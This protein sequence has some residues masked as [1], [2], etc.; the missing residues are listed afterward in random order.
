MRDRLP[1]YSI[2]VA[3][4]TSKFDVGRAT[5][6]P[7]RVSRGGMPS[8]VWKLTTDRGVFSVKRVRRD[9]PQWWLDT[10]GA[11]MD[12]E[13]R[14]LASGVT[15]PE[16]IPPISDGLGFMA[17]IGGVPFRV[18]RWIDARP[19]TA[20]ED[21]A[22][23][24]GRTLAILHSLM[25]TDAPD[26]QEYGLHPGSEWDEWISQARRQRRPWS[27]AA[28]AT[29]SSLMDATEFVE[30]ALAIGDACCYAHRDFNPWNFFI[31]DDG[32]AVIDFDYAGPDVAWLEL[33][34][35][36][37]ELAFVGRA[38]PDVAVVRT[39]VDAY[40]CAGGRCG[41][42]SGPLALGRWVGSKLMWTAWNMWRSLGHRPTTTPLEMAEAD[43]IVTQELET[44]P[45]FLSEIDRWSQLVPEFG[46]GE[47]AARV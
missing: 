45:R 28:V 4:I 42:A 10:V 14:A 7:L 11:S 17:L 30:A 34:S 25:P 20:L 13:R 2:D 40:V 27:D 44:W 8:T 21:I 12:F 18:H 46:D 15:V 47:G 38:E 19:V 1:S 43:R 35:S 37:V 29:R 22:T 26:R 16:P 6:P 5:E 32:P 31:T 24:V 33:I 9:T 23:W 39:V 3:A 36:A 41:K